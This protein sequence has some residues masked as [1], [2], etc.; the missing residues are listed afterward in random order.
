MVTLSIFKDQRSV[1][2]PAGEYLFKEGDT[3]DT[4]YVVKEGTLEVE[5]NGTVVETVNQGGIVGEMA[6]ID[7][8]ERSASVRAATDA[9]VVPLDKKRF[10]FFVQQTPFFATQVMKLLAERVR[11]TNLRL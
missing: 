7:D 10:E 5:V 11:N 1:S 3:G 4:M 8:S 6:L 9:E 2:C